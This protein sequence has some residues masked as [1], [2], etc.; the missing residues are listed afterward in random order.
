MSF[1]RVFPD[2]E[3]WPRVPYSE[4]LRERAYSGLRD[5][6]YPCVYGDSEIHWVRFK[7]IIIGGIVGGMLEYVKPPLYGDIAAFILDLKT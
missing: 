6:T 4:F 1:V 7:P 2:M 3:D 5:V